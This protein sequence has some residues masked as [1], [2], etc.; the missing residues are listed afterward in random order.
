MAP[1]SS[2]LLMLILVFLA[3]LGSGIAD[4]TAREM[5][6]VNCE[7]W[8]SL[9]TKPDSASE[10]IC[11][12]KL[13][14]IVTNCQ[15]AD[16]GFLYC[17]YKTYR[18]YIL[19]SY[20]Q[21]LSDPQAT[22]RASKNISYEAFTADGNLILR[23]Y[24]GSHTVLARILQGEHN[25]TLQIAAFDASFAMAWHFE[26]QASN[27]MHTTPCAAFIG[28]TKEK[29]CVM[30]YVDSIGL[31]RMNAQ[32]G[33]PEWTL[34]VSSIDF[35]H[36]ILYAVADDGTMF[37]AAE[38][39]TSITAV[40]QA[41]IVLWQSKLSEGKPQQIAITDEKTVAVTCVSPNI[42]V[43]LDKNGNIL[44]SQHVEKTDEARKPSVADSIMISPTTLQNTVWM[45]QEIQ[46]AQGVVLQA[47]E[48][49]NGSLDFSDSAA[50]FSFTQNTASVNLNALPCT[51]AIG[52]LYSSCKNT[53]W[54]GWL[55]YRNADLRFTCYRQNGTWL[56]EMQ[57][58]FREGNLPGALLE[59]CS[60]LFSLRMESSAVELLRSPMLWT[61]WQLD[62]HNVHALLSED[63][64]MNSVSR[65]MY[66]IDNQLTA[67]FVRYPAVDTVGKSIDLSET[68]AGSA[69]ATLAMNRITFG[70][71]PAIVLAY[72]FKNSNID[73][74]G[75]D[76][77]ITANGY[78]YLFHTIA[79]KNTFSN[80]ADIIERWRQSLIF[81]ERDSAKLNVF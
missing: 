42:T 60:L 4:E 74:Y 5:V 78:T 39:D 22:E 16:N 58:S 18:G 56:L 66:L 43:Y 17:E 3:L 13:G 9:R 33:E 73:Y 2:I 37:I 34:P 38:E 50:D 10:R 15:S 61:D 53:E 31:I 55:E 36:N 26:M 6:V 8:V 47:S 44:S 30:A 59:P 23:D 63:D 32:T 14:E 72:Q 81:V 62:G 52:S 77:L 29:P 12:V 40:S 57:C 20:L 21:L 75:E 1:K 49:V 45:L 28:G 51:F 41:G 80:Y 65:E 79:E 24:A 69:F 67:G 54:W 19:E 11:K 27:T 64:L 48:S 35:G 46:S 7:E 25:K 70:N 71:Q 76:I 68:C